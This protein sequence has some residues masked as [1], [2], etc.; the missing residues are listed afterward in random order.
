MCE[1]IVEFD[2]AKFLVKASSRSELD[3]KITMKINGRA[4]FGVDVKPR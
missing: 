1:Y 4:P 2:S 3:A